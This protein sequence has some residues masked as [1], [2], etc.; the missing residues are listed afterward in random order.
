MF[1]LYN[2][3]FHIANVIYYYIKNSNHL[4]SKNH[5]HIFMVLTSIISF[6]IS[7]C[8]NIWL[9]EVFEMDFIFWPNSKLKFDAFHFKVII[10][11]I[12]I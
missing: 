7:K 3:D 4:D 10:F 8:T 2:Y 6:S 5:V 9:N 1:S 11:Q 12:L